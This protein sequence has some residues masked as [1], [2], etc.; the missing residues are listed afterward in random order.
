MILLRVVAIGVVIL[1]KG[2]LAAFRLWSWLAIVIALLLLVMVAITLGLDRV[3]LANQFAL[4][5]FCVLSSG[6]VL[7]FIRNL[8][9]VPGVRYQERI[10]SLSIRLFSLKTR[11]WRSFATIKQDVN[12]AFVITEWQREK[13][14]IKA[15][16]IQDGMRN[17]SIRLRGV[18][19]DQE[20]VPREKKV[21]DSSVLVQWL[22]QDKDSDKALEIRRGILNGE[23]KIAIPDLA[24][25]D[26]AD[27]LRHDPNISES[28]V[29]TA[30]QSIQG[31]GVEVVQT[32][33]L[34]E[35]AIKLTFRYKITLEQ[36]F[37][38]AL[39][40]K[41]GA[42]FITVDRGLYDNLKQLEFVKL[43]GHQDEYKGIED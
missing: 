2:I 19:R 33:A 23:I 22:I 3:P 15:Q 34:T 41:I 38:V 35:A 37:Y 16:A 30:V 25:F 26:I 6:V 13:R 39:A 10:I 40:N 14:M 24:L 4:Y 28:G 18:E 9:V 27:A 20:M 29:I 43:L 8:G 11:V 12:K 7:L 21:I 42:D 1:S 32:S 31:L 17:K 36:A 5:A